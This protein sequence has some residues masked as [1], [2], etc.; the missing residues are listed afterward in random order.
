MTKIQLILS[1][2]DSAQTTTENGWWQPLGI[3]SLAT[4]VRKHRPDVEIEILNGDIISLDEI[5]GRLDAD[6]VGI[7]PSIV[8]YENAL[9]IAHKAKSNGST[10]ILGGHHVSPLANNIIN[11][12]RGVVDFVIKHEG[13]EGLLAL[14]DS[15]DPKRIPNLVFW[16]EGQVGRGTKLAQERSLDEIPFPDFSFID[17]E[18]YFKN[19]QRRYPDS[20][21]NRPITLYSQRGC[22]WR[23]DT[24]GCLFCARMDH[25][26][27]GR[28][29]QSVVDYVF[30]LKELGAD[31]IVDSSDDFMTNEGWFNAFYDLMP[32][33]RVSF[34]IYLRPD[35]IRPETAKQLYDLGVEYVFLGIESG[36][37][38]CL[39][40]CRKGMHPSDHINAFRYLSEYG[41]KICPAFVFGFPGESEATIRTTIR[42]AERI[43]AFDNV[44]TAYASQFTPLPGSPG[45]EML[46]QQPGMG[47]KYAKEDRIS[48]SGIQQD[49]LGTYCRKITKDD[50]IAAQQAIAR[51][52]PSSTNEYRSK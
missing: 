12:Q 1:P 25:V 17:L 32:K 3:L 40:Q 21:F 43:A 36:D 30:K 39:R 45:F 4:Y 15:E 23:E 31:L 37:E 52:F 51:I 48:M 14:L 50:I 8:S 13:E 33:R 44:E 6:F 24:G 41:I 35:K 42:H 28:D 2:M 49:W 11:N 19:Y 9:V 29:P 27:K 10:T 20:R 5:L 46:L 26:W 34:R 22:T 7:Q 18:P 47:H 38:G 16:D